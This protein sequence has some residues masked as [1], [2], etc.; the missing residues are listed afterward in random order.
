MAMTE[1]DLTAVQK[2]LDSFLV[3]NQELEELTARLS[4]FNLF[5]VLRVADVEIRHSNSWLGSSCR[6]T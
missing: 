5:N 3:D 6:T 2:A 1:T 4:P